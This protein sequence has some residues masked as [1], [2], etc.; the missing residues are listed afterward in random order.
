MQAFLGFFLWP[1]ACSGL[2]PQE[3]QAPTPGTSPVTCLLKTPTF[4]A[5]V[6]LS[7]SEL[8]SPTA[9]VNSP[10]AHQI[11]PFQQQSHYLLLLSR[12]PTLTPTRGNSYP[13]RSEVGALVGGNPS[14]S[15]LF[16][17]TEGPIRPE[18]LLHPVFLS[19][20]SQLQSHGYSHELLEKLS[21]P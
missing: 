7:H 16:K 8:H 12:P 18:A 6:L 2:P 11:Q 15:L 19:W 21:T 3:A 20:C 13:R 5:P 4:F 1:S 14:Q 9:H 17:H 10:R